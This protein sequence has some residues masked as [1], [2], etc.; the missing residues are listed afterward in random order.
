MPAAGICLSLTRHTSKGHVT[1]HLET[2]QLLFSAS[3]MWPFLDH[4]Q[5]VSPVGPILYQTGGGTIK[6][7]SPGSKLARAAL[8]QLQ[9]SSCLIP[10]VTNQLHQG[11]PP[12]CRSWKNPPE[13]E[14]GLL[15]RKKSRP[16]VMRHKFQCPSLLSSSCPYRL[17]T[18]QI[19]EFRMNS[20]IFGSVV[21]NRT[22]FR[23][24][25]V[26]FC[27][28]LGGKRFIKGRLQ[29]CLATTAFVSCTAE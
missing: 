9:G 22:Q 24:S 10:A 6:I 17:H 11:K 19:S 3:Q 13:H 2:K 27:K 7:W 29:S 21:Q 26:C 23:E 4:N 1:S 8:Q 25:T 16:H 14:A 18:L 5:Q 28:F 12:P 20:W 15:T